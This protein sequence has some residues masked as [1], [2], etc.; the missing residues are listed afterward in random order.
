METIYHYWFL[1]GLTTFSTFSAEIVTA[2]QEGRILNAATG[3]LLHVG[4]SLIM[5]F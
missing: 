2:L 4:G 3:T 5:T 1:G